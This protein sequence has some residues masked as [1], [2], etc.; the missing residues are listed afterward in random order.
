MA[1]SVG[2]L[3]PF[4]PFIKRAN[5]H[6][7]TIGLSLAAGV[8]L[9]VS[10]TEIWTKS[11]DNFCCIDPQHQD[12]S[13]TLCFF[14]GVIITLLL[15]ILVGILLKLDC[16]CSCCCFGKDGNTAESNRKSRSEKN[17]RFF[18]RKSDNGRSVQATNALQLNANKMTSDVPILSSALPL[19]NGVN[20]GYTSCSNGVNYDKN[21]ISSPVSHGPIN[22]DQQSQFASESG[23]QLFVG[24]AIDGASVSINSNAP[25]DNTNNY[26]MA[27]INELF[28]NT[29]LLRMNAIIPETASLSLAEVGEKSEEEKSLSQMRVVIDNGEEG[30]DSDMDQDNSAKDGENENVS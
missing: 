25:S 24:V 23:S 19:G 3:L 2:A 27:S 16:G 5:T 26:N 21:S 1:T 6:F 15:D 17:R 8:M 12:L 10:F 11:R 22:C 9:Y 29:S 13:V 18:F 14:G 4:I 30:E 7:L 20:T 28:S